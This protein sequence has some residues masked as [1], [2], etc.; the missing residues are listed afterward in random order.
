M[1][2]AQYFSD[3]LRYRDVGHLSEAHVKT[4]ATVL[5]LIA[6]LWLAVFS[7][8]AVPARAGGDPKSCM[9]TVLEVQIKK[10]SGDWVTIFKGQKE[11][12]VVSEEAGVMIDNHEGLIPEG[13]YENVKII[14]SETI[15][16]TGRDNQNKTKPGGHLILSMTVSRAADIEQA[17]FTNIEVLKPV[18]T[19]GEEGEVT[20]HINFDYAD[21]DL[22]MEIFSSRAFLKK[23]KVKKGSVIRVGLNFDFTGQ[24]RFAWPNFFVGLETPEIVYLLPPKDVAELWMKVDGIMGVSTKETIEWTF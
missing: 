14:L 9:M 18:W 3:D 22:Q 21:R 7:F 2:P 8:F 23:L 5:P 16:F 20:Q 4:R 15:R 6:F 19:D 24:I 13:L 10:A 17:D 1:D 12:D 11:V